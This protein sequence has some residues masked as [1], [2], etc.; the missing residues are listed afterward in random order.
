MLAVLVC[1]VKVRLKPNGIHL[2]EI[3]QIEFLGGFWA[4]INVDLVCARCQ[5]WIVKAVAS[6]LPEFETVISTLIGC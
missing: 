3:A 5:N 6:S 4:D 1:V 2:T